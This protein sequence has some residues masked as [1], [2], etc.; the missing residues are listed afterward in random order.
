DPVLVVTPGISGHRHHRNVLEVVVAFQLL[1]QFIAGD[2]RHLDVHD[3]QVG[4]EGARRGHALAAVAHRLDDK[5]VRPQQV[6]EQFE[7]EFV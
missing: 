5:G 4:Q 6:A 3:D 2:V 1:D 7:I